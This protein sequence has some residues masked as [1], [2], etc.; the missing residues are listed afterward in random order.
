MQPLWESIMEVPQ[1]I[2]TELSYDPAIP[3]LDI[4]LEKNPLIRKGKCF[5]M[6]NAALFTIAKIWKQLV[7]LSADKLFKKMWYIHNGILL[8]HKN[9]RIFEFSRTWM[10]LQVLMLVT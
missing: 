10:D 1:K 2:K 3:L 5:P 4:Y 8:H 7:C 6:F 9:N